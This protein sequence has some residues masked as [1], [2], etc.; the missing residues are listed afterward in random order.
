MDTVFFRTSM[1]YE[2]DGAPWLRAGDE[3]RTHHPD[4]G[5]DPLAIV[6]KR[7]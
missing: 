1:E 7:Q 4:R 5:G 2:I 6:L 3:L